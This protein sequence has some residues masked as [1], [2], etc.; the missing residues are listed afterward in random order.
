MS[1]EVLDQA[2]TNVTLLTLEELHIWKEIEN[3]HR[4]NDEFRS[5]EKTNFWLIQ[6][7]I[8]F[9]IKNGNVSKLVNDTYRK[10]KFN[11]IQREN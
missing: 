8:I 5:R 9:E 11:L 7:P 6:K 3:G 4:F 2:Y 1:W 10:V